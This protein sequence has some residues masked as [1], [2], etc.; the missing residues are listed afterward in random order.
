MRFRNAETGWDIEYSCLFELYERAI[1]SDRMFDCDWRFPIDSHW[2]GAENS[3]FASYRE[4]L[5]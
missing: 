4:W 2:Q 1:L 3:Y 5:Y